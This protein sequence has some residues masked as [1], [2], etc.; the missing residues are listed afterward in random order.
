MRLGSLATNDL[1]KEISQTVRP[2]AKLLCDSIA[3]S[4]RVVATTSFNLL[5]SFQPIKFRS[6]FFAAARASTGPKRD[7]APVSPL[8]AFAV[9]LVT[10]VD[11]RRTGTSQL[12]LRSRLA[13]SPVCG[14]AE[15]GDRGNDLGRDRQHAIV[16]GRVT[17]E[18]PCFEGAAKSVAEGTRHLQFAWSNSVSLA[19]SAYRPASDQ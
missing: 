10:L 15:N 8:S 9:S 14:A 2:A 12:R 6:P 4:A 11:S 7:G 13:E 16:P 18:Q 17:R 3:P 1:I 19:P 5:Y